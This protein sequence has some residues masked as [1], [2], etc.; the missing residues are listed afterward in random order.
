M[1][2]FDLTSKKFIF[3]HNFY[4]IFVSVTSFYSL[5]FVRINEIRI[6]RKK[7]PATTLYECVCLHGT[8]SHTQNFNKSLSIRSVV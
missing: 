3:K 5:E 8:H 1:C 4:F 7:Q 6:E 2:V